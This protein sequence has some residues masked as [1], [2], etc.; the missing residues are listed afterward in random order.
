MKKQVRINELSLTD[1]MWL[2]W[3]EHIIYVLTV[4]FF[5]VSGKLWQ[6]KI[7]IKKTL[8]SSQQ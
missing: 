5:V 3:F 1:W 4:L 7:S 8:S 6:I 2:I